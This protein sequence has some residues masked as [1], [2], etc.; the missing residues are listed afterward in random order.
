MTHSTRRMALALA[1]G[2]TVGGAG[3]FEAGRRFARSNSRPRKA[4][5]K[6]AYVALAPHNLRR[7]AT[8]AKV[9]VVAFTDFQCPFCGRAKGTIEALLAAYPEDVAVVVKHRPL[10]FHAHAEL[11]A[12]AVQAAHRQGQG[13]AMHD[14]LFENPKALGRSELVRYA[15]KIGIDVARFEAQLEDQ[16]VLAEVQADVAVADAVGATGTPAFYV[17]GRPLR[18]A[19]PLAEFRRLVDAELEEANALL[20]SGVELAAIYERRGKALAAGN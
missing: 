13:W 17:N 5:P 12:V 6:P 20:A 16:A 1:L 7:G 11:A 8:P 19:L 3:G 2:I 10:S 14:V 9:T 4:P 18:G 15:A